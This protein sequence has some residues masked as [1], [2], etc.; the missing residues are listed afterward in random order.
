MKE[1]F[2]LKKKKHKYLKSPQK[3]NKLSMNEKN[4]FMFRS[5]KMPSFEYI[6]FNKKMS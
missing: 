4:I 3:K 5:Q 1:N 2:E 6:D